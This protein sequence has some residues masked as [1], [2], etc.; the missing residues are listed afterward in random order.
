M[1]A[2]RK[3]RSHHSFYSKPTA[4]LILSRSLHVRLILLVLFV[5]IPI[6]GVISEDV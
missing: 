1:A 5:M 3:I 4:F 6:I 2:V